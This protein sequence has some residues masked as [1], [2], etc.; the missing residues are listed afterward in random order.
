M[1]LLLKLQVCHHLLAEPRVLRGRHAHAR[2]RRREGSDEGSG[3]GVRMR[4][5]KS[6]PAPSAAR[7]PGAARGPVPARR[8]SRVEPSHG[9][10]QIARDGGGD[11][12]EG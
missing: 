3:E 1:L 11:I 7:V 5:G 6:N 10:V 2:V 8:P 9:L 4:R 12:F